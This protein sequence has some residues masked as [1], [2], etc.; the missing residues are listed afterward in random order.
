MVAAREALPLFPAADPAPDPLPDLGTP[1]AEREK[2][3]VGIVS[4][5]RSSRW[6]LGRVRFSGAASSPYSSLPEAP[7]ERAPKTGKLR[8]TV[9]AGLARPAPGRTRKRSG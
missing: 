3:P 1:P 9:R 2:R 7:K 8:R 5:R 4:A 6:R